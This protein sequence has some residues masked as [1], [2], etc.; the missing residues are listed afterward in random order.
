VSVKKFTSRVIERKD[1][2]GKGKERKT[3]E[4]RGRCEKE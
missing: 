4:Q 2:K 3:K 1:R